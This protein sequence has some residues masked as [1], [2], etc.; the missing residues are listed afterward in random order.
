MISP[1]DPR[2]AEA[3][4]E[5]IVAI[6]V[7][8]QERRLRAECED[9]ALVEMVVALGR[10]ATGPKL[11]MGDLRTPEGVY[12]IGAARPS[13]FHRFIPFD[14]PSL[15]DADIALREGRLSKADHRRIAD[16]H[17][18][19]EPPPADTALGGFLGLHGEGVRWRGDSQLLNWT[20]GCIGLSDADVD[21]IAARIA[22]GTPLSILP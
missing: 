17:A 11:R 4:C 21:F 9:G 20:L 12:R 3:L 1:A 14:Y 18:H 13:R 10:E 7:S 16:A 2:R 19:G 8:K 15:S 22:A 6:A 5:R